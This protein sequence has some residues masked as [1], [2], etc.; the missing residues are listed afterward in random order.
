MRVHDFNLGLYQRTTISSIDSWVNEL[1]AQ[2]MLD[3]SEEDLKTD[4]AAKR[5]YKY[6]QRKLKQVDKLRKK[7]C[8]VLVK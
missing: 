4:P 5:C 2:L 6:V 8:E 3:C 7:E 1:N